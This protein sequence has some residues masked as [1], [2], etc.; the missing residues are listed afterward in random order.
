MSKRKSRIYSS[1]EK[2]HR[3]KKK[4]I[5]PWS[6]FGNAVGKAPHFSSWVDSRIPELLWLILA[7]SALGQEK[8]IEKCHHLLNFIYEKREYLQN[9]STFEPNHFNLANWDSTIAE[10]FVS[11]SVRHLGEENLAPIAVLECLP[12]HSNWATVLPPPP[13]DSWELL[14]SAIAQTIDH[15]SQAST[16]IRWF[17]VAS[18]IVV[19]KVHAPRDFVDVVR[20]Y[21]SL[22]DQR[23]VRPR[24]RA[25]EMAFRAVEDNDNKRERQVVCDKFWDI[26][27]RSTECFQVNLRPTENKNTAKCTPGHIGEIYNSLVQHFSDCRANTSLDPRFDAV[28]GLSLYSTYLYWSMVSTNADVRVEGRMLLRTMFE[29][30]ATLKKLIQSDDPAIWTKYRNYGSGQAKLVFLKLD[31]DDVPRYLSSGQL[32]QYANE[33]FWMEFV[34]ID[35]GSWSKENLRETCEKLKIKDLY[36][37]YYIWTSGYVHGHWAAIRDTLYT[38]CAN[39]LHRYHRVAVEPRFD[40]PSTMIDGSKLLNLMLDLVNQAYPSFKKRIKLEEP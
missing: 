38:V 17:L 2:H 20:Q 21:P 32:E 37:K 22:G 25:M 10:V 1:L 18:G 4:L 6:H 16:D 3:D 8:F 5:A 33:D 12:D 28:A 15:Q 30:F 11:E 13:K 39:P 14:A 27:F 29:L 9:L 23:S 7:R 36:D 35:L 19:G 40:M 26:C 31:E 34:D 24:I